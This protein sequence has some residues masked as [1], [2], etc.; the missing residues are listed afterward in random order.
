MIKLIITL[1][2][3]SVSYTYLQFHFPS[4]IS[5]TETKKHSTPEN[6][7]E[8]AHEQVRCFCTD[9]TNHCQ[10]KK[11]GNGKGFIRLQTFT[12]PCLFCP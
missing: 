11:M 5:I 10:V 1:V 2:P 7:P 3:L 6:Y 12:S 8:H 4:A 9:T